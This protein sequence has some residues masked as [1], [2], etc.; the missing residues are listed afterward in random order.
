MRALG[1]ADHCVALERGV[2]RHGTRIAG[3]IQPH[4]DTM[5]P[6]APQAGRRERGRERI[7]TAE[8]VVPTR[9]ATMECV[10]GAVRQQGRQR[11]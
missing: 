8:R 6:M 10:S 3:D 2:R 7:D 4:I 11:D 5:R 1:P 9:Q